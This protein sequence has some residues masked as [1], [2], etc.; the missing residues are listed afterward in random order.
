MNHHVEAISCLDC[1]LCPEQAPSIFKR[2]DDEGLSY[3]H[4][5]PTT[6]EELASTL[7][8]MESGPTESIGRLP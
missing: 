6:G 2:D 5:Q 8:A 1:G 4:K 3:V 7:E